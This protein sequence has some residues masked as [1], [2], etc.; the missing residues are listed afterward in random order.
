ME[1]INKKCLTFLLIGL[2]LALILSA[3]LLIFK[4][5]FKKSSF[6]P[7]FFAYIFLVAYFFQPFLITFDYALFIYESYYKRE[8]NYEEIDYY[9][10]LIYKYVG[11]LGSGFSYVILP[12]YKYYYFSGYFKFYERIGHAFKRYLLEY[13][14]GKWILI[15]IVGVILTYFS[16]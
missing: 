10:T 16:D 5:D 15:I 11:Y 7:F 6:I 1:E 13:I 8:R 14:C 9:F 12:L 2:G 3:I 4:T